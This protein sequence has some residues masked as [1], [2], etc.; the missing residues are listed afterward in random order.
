M[1]RQQ[2]TI[3]HSDRTQPQAWATIKVAQ[4]AFSIHH[5]GTAIDRSTQAMIAL[6]NRWGDPLRFLRLATMIAPL[7][8]F[9]TAA[10][11]GIEPPE[12][13]NF[14]YPHQEFD[15]ALDRQRPYLEISLAAIEQVLQRIT[16]H[17]SIEAITLLGF[18]EGACLAL[19][20][21]ARN[22]YPLNAVLALSGVL[23]GSSLD[24]S[25]RFNLASSKTKVLLTAST[26]QSASLRVR[27]TQ[28]VQLLKQNGY[29]VI[30]L[31]YERRPT[32]ILP[33]ELEMCRSIILGT[34]SET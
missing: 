12:W 7:S 30:A 13:R 22:A 21:A 16:E 19:E 28:T 5:S 8:E 34:V 11:I 14:W 20:Y 1:E 24:T 15:T 18:A 31:T 2:E 26:A 3:Q 9:P 27:Y 17:V 32:T 4:H 33:E 10:I 6:C 23:L 25:D 29:K